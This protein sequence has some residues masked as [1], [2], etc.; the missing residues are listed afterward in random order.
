MKL[1]SIIFPL[2]PMTIR[3]INLL[4]SF[5]YTLLFG[6]IVNSQPLP[7]AVVER[8]IAIVNDEI[9]TLTDL[10]EYKRKLKTGGLV[11]DSLINPQ[12]VKLLLKNRKK[13]VDHLIDEK[14]MSSE[15][16]RLQL[17]VTVEKLESEIRNITKREKLSRSQL[18]ASLKQR[19]ILFSDYQDFLKTSLERR[20]LIEKEI[21]SKIK[22][23]DD[24][25]SDHY[26]KQMGANSSQTYEYTL[27]HILFRPTKKNGGWKSALERGQKVLKKLE[28]SH[29]NFAKL[30]SQYSEDSDF[31][32]GGLLGTFKVGEM[33]SSIEKT[34]K[35]MNPS[36]TSQLVKS[37]AGFHILKL[38]KRKLVA[39]PLFEREKGKIRNAL[40]YKEFQKQLRSWL[41]RKRQDAF[42]KIN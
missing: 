25:I 18:K 37:P 36:E 40:F 16:K 7:A 8:V 17:T 14:I 11:D 12:K 34:V 39:D 10:S 3:I 15:I 24:D 28:S 19:G 5:I 41:D 22:I 42:I 31:T 20:S 30:A 26:I 13:L 29:S 1:S 9:I 6:L 32:Q 35:K 4:P 23:S 38:L 33:V 21:T 27:A 2:K